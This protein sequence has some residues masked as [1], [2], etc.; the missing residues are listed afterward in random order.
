MKIRILKDVP[1]KVVKNDI[2]FKFGDVQMKNPK[3]AN[4]TPQYLYTKDPITQKLKKDKRWWEK[5]K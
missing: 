3:T 4:R 1:L 5:K 2:Q